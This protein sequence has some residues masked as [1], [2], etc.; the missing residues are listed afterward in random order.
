MKGSRR[1]G[2]RR[3]LLAAVVVVLAAGAAGSAE[4]TPPPAAQTARPCTTLVQSTL[5]QMTVREKVG[6]MV[7]ALNG[8]GFGDFTDTASLIRDAH[9][10]SV[11]S[12]GY[13]GMDPA[14]SASHN[15]S[16]QQAAA[17]TRLGIPI[18]NAADFEKGVSALVDL[19]TTEF[20]NQLGL[21]A[22]WRV[23]DAATAAEVT[24]VEAR[25]MGFSWALAP[26][27]DVIT[28]PWN[29]EIGVRS[30]GSDAETAATLTARHVQIFQKRGLV[31][32]AKHFLGVGATDTNSH[33]ELP[34]VTV[35]RDTLERVHARP[36]KAA[37]NAG[38]ET[39]MTANVVVQALDP[40]LPASLSQAVTTG[41]LRE[42]LGFDGVIVTDFMTAGGIMARW[43]IDEAA[44]LAVKAGADIVMELGPTIVPLIAI[45]ALVGAV[46]SG[47][48]SEQRVDASVRRI[49]ALKCRYGLFDNPYVDPA[50]A[51]AATGTVESRT[52]S[53][54]ISRRAITLVK[55]DDVLPFDESNGATTLVAGVT[56]HSTVID[57]PSVS[58]ATELAA[59]IGSVSDGPVEWWAAATEDPTE[60]EVA[61]A[62]GRTADADRIVVATYSAGRLPEGQ[63]RLVEALIATGKPV[64]A[65]SIGTPGDV[66][67][68]PE[69]GAYVASYALNFLPTYIYAP[70]A[71]RAA[72]E[73]LFG[74]EPG[75]RLPVAL[76]D[77]YPRGHGLTYRATR[78]R[79]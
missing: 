3:T 28:N 40:D 20:P 75:G 26:I 48:I 7:M 53:A 43:G 47:E 46:G 24:A 1:R 15:N 57:T 9:V 5:A 34:I 10:G 61:D 31:A 68:Y 38:V 42:Q 12:L 74:A 77:A 71:L 17:Q 18:L 16:L 64:A 13:F 32:T 62:V 59:A 27:A 11:V 73:V 35:D 44:V 78:P 54:A 69:V 72:A 79:P 76:G 63:A 50:H 45:E 22:T 29:G 49:L 51:A 25:A 70:A 41:M 36:F 55:N 33:F 39:I 67:S 14:V 8:P 19:G 58:H 21:G 52:E 23:D 60:S 56:S 66:L 30:F 37:I 6:Q 2:A 4:G 65:V